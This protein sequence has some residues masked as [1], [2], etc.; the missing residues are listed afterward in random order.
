MKYVAIAAV[1]AALS[2]GLGLGTAVAQPG[3]SGTVIC[4]FTS[5][6]A[7][8]FNYATIKCHDE[9]DP[10]NLRYSST[11][12]D[13]EDKQVYDARRKLS[14]RS[15]KCQLGGRTSGVQVGQMIVTHYGLRG[16]QFLR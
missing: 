11:V 15:M 6:P 12:W 2:S 4:R 9:G 5:G 7:G 3:G 1:F 8:N 10:L 13:S 14:G 16:C